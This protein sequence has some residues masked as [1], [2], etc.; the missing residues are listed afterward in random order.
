MCR[1]GLTFYTSSLHHPL[2]YKK[3]QKDN[4]I[5]KEERDHSLPSQVSQPSKAKSTHHKKHKSLNA[6]HLNQA[7]KSIYTN[8]HK[9]RRKVYQKTMTKDP[10]IQKVHILLLRP[11]HRK[12]IITTYINLLCISFLSSHN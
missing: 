8:I 10:I 1:V 2:Q 12:H 3:Q 7:Q 9:K 4:K 5:E 6:K 11:S